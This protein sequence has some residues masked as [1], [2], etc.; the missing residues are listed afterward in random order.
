[1]GATIGAWGL[2]GRANPRGSVEGLAKRDHFV[3][4]KGELAATAARRT[5]RA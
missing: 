3:G 1:M 2:K 4:R 5:V